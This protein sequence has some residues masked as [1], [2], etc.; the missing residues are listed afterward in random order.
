MCR[1][2]SV[3]ITRHTKQDRKPGPAHG[4]GGYASNVRMF[5]IFGRAGEIPD[6]AEKSFSGVPQ[7]HG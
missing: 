2:I 5:A 7:V 3:V 1:S 4:W 6:L